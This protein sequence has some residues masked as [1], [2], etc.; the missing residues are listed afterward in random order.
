M[1]RGILTLVHQF[2]LRV[3]K[4]EQ[5]HAENSNLVLCESGEK[6]VKWL[7]FQPLTRVLAV[8]A[9]IKELSLLAAYPANPVRTLTT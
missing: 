2:S 6:N 1:V 7:E 4:P 3:A 5:N 9:I 8:A